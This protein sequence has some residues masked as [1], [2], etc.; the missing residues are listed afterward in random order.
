[1][2]DK[3]YVV[4]P[5][6]SSCYGCWLRYEDD[7]L[8]IFCSMNEEDVSNYA[9]NKPNWCPIKEFP[10]EDNENY[11]PDEFMDGMATG[12]NMCLKKIVGGNNE[13]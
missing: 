5:I 8:G 7:R 12:W 11:F 6:P 9:F 1:M 4:V 2:L 10:K 13:D 3:G